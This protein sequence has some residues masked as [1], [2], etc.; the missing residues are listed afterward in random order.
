MDSGSLKTN[1]NDNLLEH[2]LL[3]R[4]R[5]TSERPSFGQRV[6]HDFGQK[7]FD[8][9]L[10][11]SDT[12][13]TQVGKLFPAFL[14]LHHPRDARDSQCGAKGKQ[15]LQ[16]GVILPTFERGG[17]LKRECGWR[18][19]GG[20]VGRGWRKSRQRFARGFCRCR[21]QARERLERRTSD[22]QVQDAA[23]ARRVSNSRT[24]SGIM[25]PVGTHK[26]SPS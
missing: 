9:R 26:L 8:D 18:Y 14:R 4:S 16:E 12:L 23:I 10:A 21:N 17:K 5:S 6:Y 2:L 19:E 15:P 24:T 25:D 13:P 11:Q 1:E 7:R 22:L 20:E 3:V